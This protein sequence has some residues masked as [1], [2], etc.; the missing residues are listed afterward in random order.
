[1]PLAIKAAKIA[2]ATKKPSKK[3][4][5]NFILN[6]FEVQVRFELTYKRVCN[7]FHLTT[8]ALNQIIPYQPLKRLNTSPKAN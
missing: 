6:L 4:N 2:T 7:P 3:I 5:T 1:M 8:L